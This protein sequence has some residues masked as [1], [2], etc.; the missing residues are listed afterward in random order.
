MIMDEETMGQEA[1]AGEGQGGESDVASMVKNLSGGLTMI[2]QMISQM[3]DASPEDIQE[4]QDISDR[5]QSLMIKIAGGGGEAA[6]QEMSPKGT[7]AV[8][9][10]SMAGK[11][12]GPAGI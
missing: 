12:V 11:P 5:F 4:A 8:P 2:S 9:V 10:Q 6:P 3:P 1:A 7:K